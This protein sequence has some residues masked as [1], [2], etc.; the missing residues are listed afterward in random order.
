[1]TIS[2]SVS[3]EDH[4]L[5]DRCADRAHRIQ[6]EIG[7]PASQQQSVLEWQMDIT[8]VHAN[9][10]PLRL[11]SLSEAPRGDFAHDVFGIMSHLDR[12][13]GQLGSCFVPRY[14]HPERPVAE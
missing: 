4:M 5:I 2:F 7:A 13:T 8:A 6:G 3:P 9:G 11:G 14:A 10:M 1:M 12:K